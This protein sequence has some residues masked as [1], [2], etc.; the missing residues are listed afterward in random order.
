[1]TL[2]HQKV[3]D[4]PPAG[5]QALA[6]PGTSQLDPIWDSFRTFPPKFGEER[7]NERAAQELRTA[8]GEGR[9]ERRRGRPI[10]EVGH[11]RTQGSLSV[12]Y[13]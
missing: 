10:A 1:M 2:S 8:G 4:S 6:R 11:G 7:A 5:S 12:T 9:G 3:F 13:R